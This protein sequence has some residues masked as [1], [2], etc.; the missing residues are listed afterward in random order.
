[1]RAVEEGRSSRRPRV[2]CRGRRGR[3]RDEGAERRGAREARRFGE[4]D[5]AGNPAVISPPLASASLALS[6]LCQ[7]N[8]WRYNSLQMYTAQHAATTKTTTRAISHGVTTP[9]LILEGK[10]EGME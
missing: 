6:L 9:R 7:R 5:S 4:I 10:S 1:M 2:E 3:G 8:G